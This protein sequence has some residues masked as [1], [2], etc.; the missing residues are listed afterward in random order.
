MINVFFFT[1]LSVAALYQI[2]LPLS[3]I[4]S[5]YAL[6]HHVQGFFFRLFDFIEY[7]IYTHRYLGT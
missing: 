4:S 1:Q 6:Y 3:C 7:T 5:L 2:M